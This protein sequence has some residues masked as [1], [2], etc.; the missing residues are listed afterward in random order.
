[1]ECGLSLIFNRYGYI[2]TIF[3]EETLTLRTAASPLGSLQSLITPMRITE[4]WPLQSNYH[5]CGIFLL[6]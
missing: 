5:W 3:L 1:M 2:F 4:V 6:K